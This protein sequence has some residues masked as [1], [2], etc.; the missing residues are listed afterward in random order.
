MPPAESPP[1]ERPV[2]D[3]EHLPQCSPWAPAVAPFLDGTGRLPAERATLV[4]Q[5]FPTPFPPSAGHPPLPYYWPMGHVPYYGIPVPPGDSPGLDNQGIA[6]RVG[7]GESRG[8]HAAFSPA[9][10]DPFPA[11]TAEPGQS[12]EDPRLEDDGPSAVT[13]SGGRTTE[14]LR[15]A[16]ASATADPRSRVGPRTRRGNDSSALRDLLQD[17]SGLDAKGADRAPATAGFNALGTPRGDGAADNANGSASRG[18]RLRRGEGQFS[19]PSSARV[20]LEAQVQSST[21]TLHGLPALDLDTFDQHS[22][23]VGQGSW[24][25]TSEV[26]VSKDLVP[27]LDLLVSRVLQCETDLNRLHS[28]LGCVADIGDVLLDSERGKGEPNEQVATWI[29]LA[30]LRWLSDRFP[31][32]AESLRSELAT[33]DSSAELAPPLE[34]GALFEYWMVSRFMVS[35]CLGGQ[36]QTADD[37]ADADQ[38]PVTEKRRSNAIA[39]AEH[40]LRRAKEASKTG[41]MPGRLGTPPPSSSADDG[42]KP[43]KIDTRSFQ[44]IEPSRHRQSVPAP[45]QAGETVNFDLDGVLGPLQAVRSLDIVVN[46]R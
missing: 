9:A 35:A 13:S 30:V 7:R 8:G 16:S 43:A 10:R 5:P 25:E 22:S 14:G 3:S 37:E 28:C 20:S 21:A 1:W 6:P 2:P 26:F 36:T 12:G 4:S 17:P 31:A 19:R 32:A 11:A 33:V 44:E 46:S 39:R 29:D 24:T 40:L 18:Q 42:K 23:P 15:G 41:T 45:L 34:L 27:T 38:T